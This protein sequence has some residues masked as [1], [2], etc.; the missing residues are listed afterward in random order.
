MNTDLLD[1]FSK[2]LIFLR[3]RKGVKQTEIADYLDVRPSNY[4]NWESGLNFPKNELLVKIS[5]FYN[6]TIDGLLIKD[7]A[8]DSSAVT[9]AVDIGL[10]IALS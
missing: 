5:R 4:N 7:G 1:I 8:I 10:V 2:N 9:G 6:V 3:N